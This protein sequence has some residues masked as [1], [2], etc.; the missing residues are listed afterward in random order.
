MDFTLLGLQLMFTIKPPSRND[1]AR[2]IA[3]LAK[4]YHPG[5]ANYSV[6]MYSVAVVITSAS[7][8]I[9]ADFTFD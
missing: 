8:D 9:K 5:S 4:E 6:I 1:F 3:N 7:T 2:A